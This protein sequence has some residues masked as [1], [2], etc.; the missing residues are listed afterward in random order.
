[1]VVEGKVSK[2]LIRVFDQDASTQELID[3]VSRH[4]G[5]N[6]RA[7]AEMLAKNSE[8]N[9]N[10]DLMLIDKQGVVLN[11]CSSDRVGQNNRFRRVEALFEY[12]VSLSAFIASNR[13][14]I[15]LM[16]SSDS[17]E[18]QNAHLKLVELDVVPQSVSARRAWQL[19]SNEFDLV[20][21][22]A[23]GVSEGKGTYLDSSANK[24]HWYERPL[25]IIFI[26][27]SIAILSTILVSVLDLS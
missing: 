25:G 13:K 11:C 19:I 23:S 27:V 21:M 18:W 6:E 24:K 1:M 8:L 3:L 12:A 9:F 5:M 16:E 10:D 26:G 4:P 20:H 17:L 7:T 15:A 14:E 22:G 2:P